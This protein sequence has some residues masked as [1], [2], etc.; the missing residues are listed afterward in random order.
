MMVPPPRDG[1][2][3]TMTTTGTKTTTTCPATGSGQRGERAM[4]T[5]A[6]M[7]NT[8]TGV[9][10]PR[11]ADTGNG[12]RRRLRRDGNNN[13]DVKEGGLHP[14]TPQTM[15]TRELVERLH[16]AGRY[17]Q[18]AEEGEGNVDDAGDN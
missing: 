12:R 15:V 10:G 17:W 6:L 14:T 4:S 9:R 8:S 2:M 13:Y 18:R 16:S 3:M 5:M 7:M 1:R 11:L